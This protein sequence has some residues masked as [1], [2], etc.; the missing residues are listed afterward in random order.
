MWPPR[1]GVQSEI[2]CSLVCTKTQKTRRPFRLPTCL[3]PLSENRTLCLGDSLSGFS[4]A[5]GYE[6]HSS[7]LSR[8][9][10]SVGRL[11]L[12]WGAAPLA[13]AATAVGTGPAK[14]ARPR[15]RAFHR[16]GWCWDPSW[17]R[18][19]RQRTLRQ[20]PPREGPPSRL[21]PA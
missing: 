20:E 13:P 8:I 16:R 7:G 18:R 3:Q 19:P 17:G 2:G 4:G 6:R 12:S 21:Q 5:L 9:T 1:L 14:V 10:Q 11:C 15:A